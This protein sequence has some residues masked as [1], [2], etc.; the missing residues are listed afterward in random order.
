MMAVYHF[1]AVNALRFL[2]NNTFSSGILMF[3]LHVIIPALWELHF[4]AG[5]MD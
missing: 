4:H 3:E 1:L 5:W 2:S